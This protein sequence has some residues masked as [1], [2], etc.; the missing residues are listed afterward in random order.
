MTLSARA[1]IYATLSMTLALLA[2]CGTAEYRA[3]RGICEARWLDK[4]PPVYEDR[5]VNKTRYEERP[6]GETVCETVNGKTKCTAE[7]MQVSVPYVAV[8]TVDINAR[9]RNARITQC[10][11]RRCL[12]AYGNTKC[13]TP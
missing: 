7:T 4:L 9:E 12:E 1:R 2:G 13:E 11:Q 6:T 8:E 3:E 5:L 10:A